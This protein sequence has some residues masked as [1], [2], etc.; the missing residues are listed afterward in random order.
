M[1]EVRFRLLGKQMTKILNNS[2]NFALY[3]IFI[4]FSLFANP[5]RD[6]ARLGP[7]RS[8]AI[9]Q[10]IFTGQ[11][12]GSVARDLKTIRNWSLASNLMMDDDLIRLREMPA[13]E[14]LN[15]RGKKIT[16]RFFSKIHLPKLRELWL[17]SENLNLEGI[18]A[19]SNV[20]SLQVLHIESFN[21]GNNELNSLSKLV[22]LKSLSL[23]TKIN[24]MDLSFLS[25]MKDLEYLN[26]SKNGVTDES[27]KHLINHGQLRVLHLP[28]TEITE[29]SLHTLSI[30]PKLEFLGL[31][32]TRINGGLFTLLN[33]NSNLIEISLEETRI[34]DDSLQK[35]LNLKS[36][37]KLWLRKTAV[38]D[39]GIAN[40]LINNPSLDFLDL[41]YLPIGTKTSKAIARCDCVKDLYVGHTQFN[42]E[43]LIR[44][45]PAKKLKYLNLTRTEVTDKG[46]VP[47]QKA[48][49][50]V[51]VMAL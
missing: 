50:D 29:E 23:N 31:A 19:I 42:D 10:Y 1:G 22:K 25:N 36:L 47:F 34:D 43:D 45:I 48:R 26:L 14:V 39:E 40:F 32:D 6:S 21:L 3:L 12:K 2:L 30:L 51:Q 16:A 17:E 18:N 20:K 27:I 4:A 44:L 38:T 46:F 37:R 11:K 13:L 49:P 8:I 28:T 41:G 33:R 15:I 5:H 9:D 24:Q 7:D 35:L